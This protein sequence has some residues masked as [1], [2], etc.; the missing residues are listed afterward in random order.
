MGDETLCSSDQDALPEPGQKSK[1]PSKKTKKR[2]QPKQVKTK[3]QEAR[4]PIAEGIR[5]FA[6]AGRPTKAQFV[7]VYGPQ[8]HKRIGAQ[9]AEA[10]VD[11]EHFQ[12]ALKAKF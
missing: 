8:G 4:A 7:K 11:V 3:S 1:K 2:V 5:L 12:E 10:G 6:L 9:R